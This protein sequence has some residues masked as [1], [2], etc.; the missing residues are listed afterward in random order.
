MIEVHYQS[1]YEM[2]VDSTVDY[3]KAEN[4]IKGP[5]TYLG[6]VVRDLQIKVNNLLS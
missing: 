5:L 6:K 3:R 1:A 2:T 4:E